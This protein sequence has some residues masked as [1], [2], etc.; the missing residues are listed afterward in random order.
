MLDHNHIKWIEQ[1]PLVRPETE[2]INRGGAFLECGNLAND[3]S[4]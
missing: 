1:S 3:F 4:R 2:I